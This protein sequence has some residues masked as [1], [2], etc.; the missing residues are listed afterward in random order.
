MRG[1]TVSFFKFL[2]VPRDFNPRSSWE[3]RLLR[4]LKL[5]NIEFISIH[6]PRERSEPHR[7]QAVWT[8]TISIHAPR[9]RSDESMTYTV[10]W[11]RRFQSTLLVRGATL[12]RRFE[13]S[14]HIKISIH[15]PRERSDGFYYGHLSKINVFQSTLL[16]RGATL[17]SI[18]FSE[19]L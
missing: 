9:E 7:G 4:V 16:V 3:E 13:I 6:A 1:A 12:F 19:I 14:I 18:N 2:S 15:A 17:Q 10:C 8:M 5:T 11:I